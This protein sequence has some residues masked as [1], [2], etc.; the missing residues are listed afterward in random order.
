MAD[1]INYCRKPAY[2]EYSMF[3]CAAPLIKYQKDCKFHAKSSVSSRCMHYRRDINRHCDCIEAQKDSVTPTDKEKDMRLK[4]E[5]EKEERE[6]KAVKAAKEAEAE[7]EKAKEP[8]EYPGAEQ[9]KSFIDKL[10]KGKP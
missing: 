9:I 6:V 1:K 8:G 5:K 7:E 4:S 2:N 3:W 10:G